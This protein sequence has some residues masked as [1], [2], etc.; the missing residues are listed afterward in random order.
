M[1]GQGGSTSLTAQSA[2]TP[3]NKSSRTMPSAF[4]MRRAV[5][6]RDLT[7]D[8]VF[9]L[10]V[11]STNIFCRPSCNAR[12]PLEKNMVFYPTA[13]EALFAGY[14]PC[15]RC[16]PLELGAEPEWVKTLFEMIEKEP[17]RRFRDYDLRKI[18]IEPAKARRYFMSKYNMTF[19]AYSRSRRLG[20]AFSQI[21][22]GNGLDDVILGNGYE[23]HSGFRDAFA[24]IFGTPPG[25]ANHGECIVTTMI[26]SPLGALILGATSKALCL[27]EF[28]DRRMFENQI[29][30]LRKRFN[31]SIVPGSNVVIEQTKKELSEYFEGKLKKFTMPLVFPG[32]DFQHKVWSELRKIPYGKT[33]SY[34]ELAGRAGADG[35]CRA[36]G[37]ANGANRIAIIIP[38]HRVV[39]KSGKLGGYGGGLWRKQRL[40]EL[41]RGIK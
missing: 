41:E 23:S 5:N 29:K 13:K 16:K 26:E 22:Q 6:N 7:Y 30:T 24:K 34:E 12:K 9:Y 4:E 27:L 36:V 14:R 17:D 40:L 10:A 3:L 32:T 19:Q 35:A 38:C 21:R 2:S 33:I 31:C 1:Y 39:N 11:K 37:T 15:K 18:G 28:S 20:T 25:K 8:G